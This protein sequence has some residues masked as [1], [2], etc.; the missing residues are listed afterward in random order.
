MIIKVTTMIMVITVVVPEMRRTDVSPLR[1][2]HHNKMRP[3]SV[4]YPAAPNAISIRGSFPSVRP[5]NAPRHSPT[6]ALPNAP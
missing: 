3:V 4:R 1:S 5:S 2:T 6:D